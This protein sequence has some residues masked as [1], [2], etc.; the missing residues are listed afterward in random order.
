MH[1]YIILA[2][3]VLGLIFVI[4]ALVLAFTSR[5]I[6]V[7]SSASV[8]MGIGVCLIILAAIIQLIAL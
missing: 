1:N 2:L 6:K 8:S 5:T 3:V 4:T 7:D